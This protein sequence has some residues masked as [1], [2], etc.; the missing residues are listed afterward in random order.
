ME[1]PIAFRIRILTVFVLFCL[2]H[3]WVAMNA[4]A[5]DF[6][7]A[8]AELQAAQIKSKSARYFNDEMKRAQRALMQTA[9]SKINGM[10]QEAWQKGPEAVLALKETLRG[11]DLDAAMDDIK[12]ACDILWENNP[13]KIMP[14]D[15]LLS[16]ATQAQRMASPQKPATVNTDEGKGILPM[17]RGSAIK[18]GS[19]GTTLT[20]GSGCDY[21]TVNAALAA[22]SDGD[23]ILLEGGVTFVEN[24]HIEKNIILQGAYSGCSTGV[25]TA[26]TLDGN[27]SG[28]VVT[29]DP[30]LIV[31]LKYLV[32]TNGRTG[33]EGGGIKF[34]ISTGTGQLTIDHVDIHHNEAYWGGG[35]WM[36]PETVVIGNTVNIYENTA[37]D[38]GGGLRLYTAQAY[39]SNSNIYNNTAAIGGGVAGKKTDSTLS[40]E[41]HLVSSADVFD[42]QALIGE[43]SGGGIYMDQGTINISHCSDIISND[44]INGG[45]VYMVETTLVMEGDCSEIQNNTAT[46]DGGG[47]YAIAT[48]DVG[49]GSVV[50][51]DAAAEIYMNSAQGN[52]GGLY[53]NNSV[54]W[55]DKSSIQYNTAS[56]HGGGIFALNASYVDMDLGGY[57]CVDQ[58]C[59]CLASNT[60]LN[61]GGGIYTSDE[62][63][64]DLGQTYVEKNTAFLGGGIYGNG[65]NTD[66]ILTNVLIARNNANSTAGDGIRVFSGASLTGYHVTMAYNDLSGGSA[67]RAI[68]LF[69]ANLNLH[70]SV[71]WGHS[72]SV[73][74]TGEAITN[75]DIQGGYAGSGNMDINPEFMNP[76]GGDFRLMLSSPVIDRCTHLLSRDMENDLRPHAHVRPAT[77][78]D[79]G[80]DEY[81]P[82]FDNDGISDLIELTITCTDGA[83]ADTDHDGI[84]DGVEDRNCNGIVDGSETN[85]CDAD[86]DDDGL[87]DGNEDKNRNQSTDADETSALNAD[88]DNDGLQD[89][90]EKGVAVAH[91][92]TGPGFQPD[93]DPSTQTDPLKADTDGDGRIDGKEDRNHNGRVDFG[94]TDP[95]VIDTPLL[96]MAIPTLLLI[97]E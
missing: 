45:G 18:P 90:T 15:V 89:G 81:V 83:V 64:L 62:S 2:F 35:I 78:Y 38:A 26:T 65:N 72:S 16:E 25:S 53:L 40:P 82:D 74:L 77:P 22:A 55:S 3:S 54:L 93:M 1:K 80:A 33:S 42:N 19:S 17:P 36:G 8:D 48:P 88:S 7:E 57:A 20:V 13:P 97:D 73:N 70:R 39:F 61:Y 58:R 75:S 34:G 30:G 6:L 95:N 50:N 41:L 21:T 49:S 91:A 44:A 87:L 24:I 69:S 23:T 85:A 86:T 10:V 63:D 4:L 47:V 79:M 5:D 32:I 67:G 68:D 76:A 27:L 71:I 94:E 14:T 9:T 84:L 12:R 43:G 56:G 96:P 51:L 92:D 28:T 11:D 60:A 59:S 31:E 29:I 37:T 52:G 66:I 46:Q